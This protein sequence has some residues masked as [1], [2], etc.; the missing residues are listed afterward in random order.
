MTKKTRRNEQAEQQYDDEFVEQYDVMRDEY[1]TKSEI[2]D[3][4]RESYSDLND[5]DTY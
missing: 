2:Y 3:S 5:Y 4:I 1:F